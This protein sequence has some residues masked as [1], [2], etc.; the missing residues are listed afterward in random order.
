MFELETPCF[1][2]TKLTSHASSVIGVLD[3]EGQSTNIADGICITIY[4][5]YGAVGGHTSKQASAI[6]DNI[7]H[8][9]LTDAGDHTKD[10][11]LIVGDINGDT[12]DFP[13]L[14]A[15]FCVPCSSSCPLP[16]AF[17]LRTAATSSPLS[18]FSSPSP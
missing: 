17:P 9:I 14:A 5:I 6:T 12:N 1:V 7:I 3:F 11:I 13:S 18:A 2:L 4:N 8:A 16:L 15:A 10:P